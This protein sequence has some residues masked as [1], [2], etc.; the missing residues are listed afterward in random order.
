LGTR[1]EAE[2]VVQDTFVEVWRHAREE[3]ARGSGLALWIAGIARRRA[4]ER[5]G[6]RPPAHH[7]MPVPP[8]PVDEVAQ[9]LPL[10]SA[11]RRRE[12]RRVASVLS[13]LPADQRGVVEMAWFSCLSLA[14]I[15]IRTSEPVHVVQTRLRAGME[16]LAVLLQ[17]APEKSA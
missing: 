4:R 16:R 17:Q 13:R 14:D 10:E 2:A 12:R 15:A 1:T 11:T 8:P 3:E 9:P 5:L 6:T 7:D